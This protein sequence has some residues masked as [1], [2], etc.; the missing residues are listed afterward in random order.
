[1]LEEIKNRVGKELAAYFESAE[2][3]YSLKTISPLLFKNLREFSCRPGK[4][5]R[6]ILSLLAY[7]AF[8]GKI[9]PWL[10]S[11]AVSIELLHDFMLIHDDIIDKSPTRRGKPSMHMLFNT[12]LARYKKVKF[13]GEDMGII[14]GDVMFAMAMHSFLNIKVHPLK[15]ELA[16]KKLLESAL[17]TA[18]GE[19]IELL[20][21][22]KKVNK[23][24]KR[25][26]YRI[27]DLKTANYTFASPLAI[28]A[29]LAGAA[30]RQIGALF[31]YGTY[32]GR[33][34]QIKDDLIGMFGKEK[35]TGK[36][37]LTDLS[38]GK[39]TILIWQAYRGS[40]AS[41]RKTIDKILN[42]GAVRETDL[43]IARRII[44][45]SGALGLCR[46][47][48]KTLIGKANRL[49]DS[50]AMRPQYKTIL[51]KYSQEILS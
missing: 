50:C 23:I 46:Q 10:Y 31:K 6:P 1:M 5:I 4:R 7:S 9:P 15:K 26:I 16:L 30:P 25:E 27:Y 17:Y 47:E 8:A 44:L 20:Y 2:K 51:K 29:T 36:S 43:F 24:T 34:F 11:C 14:S 49:L 28:G 45:E 48:I 42:A 3:R 35:V 21:G 39:K 40:N 33:A 41:D 38:E 19:F 13:S 22:I 12:Y 18:S 32:L 37:G